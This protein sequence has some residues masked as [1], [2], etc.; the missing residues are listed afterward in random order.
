[1]MYKYI[2]N[3]KSNTTLEPQISDQIIANLKKNRIYSEI[4]EFDSEK[5]L[6]EI[7]SS[8]DINTTNTLILIGDDMDFDIFIGQI[9]K[10][11]QE[12]S[13]GFIPLTKS[14]LTP[15]TNIHSWQNAIE[16]MAQRKIMERTIYSVASRYFFDEITLES[17]IEQ[18]IPDKSLHIT[19]DGNL[20]IAIPLAKLKFENIH[21][22]QYFSTTPLQLTVFRD[23]QTQLNQPQKQLFSNLI[24]YF[25]KNNM[26]KTSNNLILSIHCKTFKLVFDREI[27]D[28]IGRKYKSSLLVGKHNRKLKLITKKQQQQRK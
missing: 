10:L 26:N 17:D 18:N 22:D 9:G 25:N 2:K 15:L 16:A 28:S 14:R 20:E 1:M 6:A 7:L 11:D 4:I 24:G 5:K 13:I 21:E 3:T 19:T 23:D 12:I 27:K 8:I